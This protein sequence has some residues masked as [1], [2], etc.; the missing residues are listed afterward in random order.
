MWRVIATGTATVGTR[1]GE[2]EDLGGRLDREQAQ[3]EQDTQGRGVDQV[4]KT[5]HVESHRQPAAASPGQLQAT[6]G[7]ARPV[8]MS[9]TAAG[10]AN[11]AGSGPLGHEDHELR[12]ELILAITGQP[13]SD[14][15]DGPRGA[16]A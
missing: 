13:D 15:A 5:K 16:V 4:S 9:P 11:A 2:G 12:G 1:P 6:K 10:Q 7:A 14:P 8:A 3:P